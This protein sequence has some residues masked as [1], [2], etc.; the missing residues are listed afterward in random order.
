MISFFLFLGGIVLGS[1]L[2]TCIHRLPRG[3][4]V[5]TPASH[6]PHCG[7]QLTCLDLIP[8]VGLM[9]LG[10]KCRYCQK[11]ISWRYP[12]VELVM[13]LL[14][15]TFYYFLDPGRYFPALVVAALSVVV[16]CTD[17]EHGLIP[18]AIVLP[19]LA[20]GIIYSALFSPY[21]L[22]GSLSGA[23][24]GGGVLLAVAL[25]SC[26]GMGGGDIKLMAAL[27]AWLGPQL[28]ILTLFLSFLLGGIGSLGLLLLKV[29]DR[30]DVIA[31]APYIAAAVFITLFGGETLY[32]WYTRLWN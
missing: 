28:V 21:T 23:F 1:F 13:G 17:L 30:R 10:G 32:N 6:C 12:L 29:K 5:L 27:G 15:V 22:V 7:Q 2:N 14:V 19:T 3:E 8:L 16:T 18:N 26:G 4:S 24:L 9:L 31:F 11:P 25:L 20:V